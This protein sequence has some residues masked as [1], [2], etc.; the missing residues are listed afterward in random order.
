MSFPCE[1]LK[2]AFKIKGG[3]VGYVDEEGYAELR[4]K[5]RVIALNQFIRIMNPA[6]NDPKQ[7]VHADEI[8]DNFEFLKKAQYGDYI[9][10]ITH[11]HVGCYVWILGYGFDSS[12]IDPMNLF[13]MP[14][15]Y[16]LSGDACETIPHSFGDAPLRCFSS[17]VHN[18]VKT[19][20]ID[21]F[22]CRS[23]SYLVL[24][25]SIDETIQNPIKEIEKWA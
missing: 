5:L 7:S 25:K 10:T 21:A 1:S 8:R 17:I 20:N 9:C 18:F 6:I 3:P 22:Q 13:L 23:D 2:Q 24:K 14:I 12:N 15:S 16:D 19:R 4:E 11:N